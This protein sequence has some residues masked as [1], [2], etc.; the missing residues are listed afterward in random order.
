MLLRLD[1]KTP[2]ADG[3]RRETRNYKRN[4]AIV[5]TGKTQ[6]RK[7]TTAIKLALE[8]D[9][10]FD[11][12]KQMAVVRTLDMLKVLQR[13]SKKY[14]VEIL[15]ELGVGMPHREWMKFLNKAMS[16]VMQTYGFRRKIIIV[17]V[18]YEDYVDVDARKLFDMLIKVV[19]KDDDHKYCILKVTEMEWNSKL[20]RMYYQYPR[21]KTPNGI[22]RVECFKIKYPP[23]EIMDEYF[24]ISNPIKEELGEEL[25]EMAKRIEEKRKLKHFNP[26]E[27]MKEILKNH[28]KYTTIHAHRKYI[29]RD[30]VATHFGIGIER[31]KQ[32]KVLVEQEL[33]WTK[34]RPMVD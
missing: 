30:L 14:S 13:K 7:S 18:P 25:Q 2:L 9:P 27:A 24:R 33:G 11:L 31:A 3:I 10:K 16:Y 1:S 22:K 12:K 6:M 28:E 23:K 34:N 4:Y 21:V 26:I 20:K 29:N 8:L 32:V 19:N 5:I 17:T 15:D